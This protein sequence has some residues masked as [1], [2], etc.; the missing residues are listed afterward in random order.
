MSHLYDLVLDAARAF[1][2]ETLTKSII[3][4]HCR[5]EEELI[6]AEL[7]KGRVY[8]PKEGYEVGEDII[9]PVF[10]YALGTVV[11]TRPGSNPDYGDFVVIQVAFEGD[12]EPR[13]FATE[14]VG[15]HN[16]NRDQGDTEILVAEDLRSPAELY[17]LYGPAI[18]DSLAAALEEHADFVSFRGQW[19]L[20]DLLVPIDLGLRNIAEA[21]VEIKA[22]PLPPQEIMPTLDLPA[23]VSEEIRTLSLNVA[24]DE[25]ER[26]NNVGDRGRDIWYLRRLTPED[27]TSPPSRLQFDHVPYNRDDIAEELLLIEREIDD[28]GSGEEVMGPSRPLYRT[29]ISLIYP[30]WRC[31]T[32]PLTVRTRGLFPESI[33]HHTPVIL[34]DGQ[35]GDKMQG[36]IVHGESYVYGLQ[37]W[38]ERYALP[39]GAYIKLE[40][41]RDPRV[42]T[43]D[44]EPRRL[45]HL[46]GKI[47]VA[48]DTDLVFQVRK[49]PIA[50]EY[51][52]QLTIGEESPRAID[53]IRDAV[54]TRGE[55]LLQ[56]MIRL[57][58]EL[59]KLSPQATVHAK[60]IYSAVNVL[61]RVPPGPVFAF[62]S[63]EDCF[64]PMG[65]GYWTF[66][67]TL[68]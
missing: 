50:C 54:H 6:R 67:E 65:G 18:E 36:W 28:E 22:M 16:L 68:V 48:E 55:S 12:G 30:H 24:L 52:D 56:I 29:T 58:P 66:D 13:E 17:D 62:L 42:I 49:L 61:T 41:T 60:A 1:D 53:H 33:N 14:L 47:A 9:F 38:Y 37:E 31:G 64:V 20:R 59:T 3:E 26:F 21:L 43:V 11:G 34:V 23:E 10:D 32:L 2:L 8:Q 39:V 51:D 46:W 57:M 4:R 7:S 45:K 63:T 44:F 40:R 19:Y 35:S 15:D 27:V 5:Q 25:D